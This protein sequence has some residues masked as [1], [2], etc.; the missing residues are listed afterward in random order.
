[1]L[2]IW[3]RRHGTSD[4]RKNMSHLYMWL[5]VPPAEGAGI[6]PDIAHPYTFRA[7]SCD[8]MFVVVEMETNVKK[9]TFSFAAVL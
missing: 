8:H 4:R 5:L 6:V 7:S 2:A 3:S 1:M 9:F